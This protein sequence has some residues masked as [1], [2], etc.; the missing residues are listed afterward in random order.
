MTHV[1]PIKAADPAIKAYHA[2]LKVFAEH[3]AEHEGA[4][5][6]A[7]SHLVA[8]TAKPHGWTLI[9]KK[10]MKSKATGKHIVPDGTLEDAYYLPRGYWEAKDLH[11]DLDAEIRNK[12]ARGY[13]PTAVYSAHYI[14][15]AGLRRAVARYLEEE[16]RAVQGEMDWLA[17]EYSPFKAA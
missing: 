15:D 12:I 13:L 8:R 14:E 17:E 1:A 4:T 7:F 5:E 11:D 6:T 10:G 2:D 9:P 3:R 16:R